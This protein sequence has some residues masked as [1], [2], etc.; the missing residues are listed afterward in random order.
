VIQSAVSAAQEA[1]QL[2][3]EIDEPIRFNQQKKFY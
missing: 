2:A 3:K 1:K